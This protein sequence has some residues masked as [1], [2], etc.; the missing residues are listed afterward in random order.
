MKG[1]PSTLR[2]ERRARQDRPARCGPY[3]RE[4]PRRRTSPKDLSGLIPASWARSTARAIIDSCGDRRIVD[5]G[6]TPGKDPRQ[7]I[8]SVDDVREQDFGAELG[9]DRERDLLGRA[10]DGVPVTGTIARENAGGSG[11]SSPE[12]GARSRPGHGVEQQFVD[13]RRVQDTLVPLGH[14][15]DHTP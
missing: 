9:R 7:L 5:G 13:H 15:H 1:R 3:R 8:D 10:D 2:A 11:R 14:T 12:P 6:A 4:P